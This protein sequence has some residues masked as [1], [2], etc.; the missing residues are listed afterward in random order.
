[1]QVAQW[2]LQDSLFGALKAG[3]GGRGCPCVWT[4]PLYGL[5]YVFVYACFYDTPMLASMTH[6]WAISW[7]L[8][9]CNEFSIWTMLPVLHL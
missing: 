3:A 7:Y 6:L 1:M 9:T 4:M 5:D 8:V 2:F